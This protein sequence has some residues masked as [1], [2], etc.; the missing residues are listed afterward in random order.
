M[1]TE[2][3]PQGE[4]AT[5]RTSAEKSGSTDL[6]RPPQ[7]TLEGAP[8]PSK[9]AAASAPSGESRYASQAAAA[10]PAPAAFEGGA[11]VPGDGGTTPR[12][13]WIFL[14]L[15]VVFSII[16]VSVPAVLFTG[17]DLAAAT[18]EETGGSEETPE[19]ERRQLL[20]E[21]RADALSKLHTYGPAEEA[22]AYRIPLERAMRLTL[23]E[24][25]AASQSQS[26]GSMPSPVI[27]P[28]DSA[29]TR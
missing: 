22:G 21:T 13:E 5:G 19:V 24:D 11:G 10:E 15:A 18:G 12:R 2:S 16:F 26:S 7:S 6:E 1:S 20:Q 23:Q 27:V 17:I 29:A 8:A 3:A 4:H 14:V 28:T 9:G 25:Y